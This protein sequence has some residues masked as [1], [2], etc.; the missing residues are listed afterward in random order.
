MDQRISLVTL[1]V[2]DLGAA[3]AF[4]E[5]G[6]GW[7]PSSASTDAAAFYQTGSMA[8]ALCSRDELARDVG[9]PLDGSGATLAVNL[10]SEPEVDAAFAE[11]RA[12]GAEAVKPPKRAF[13][14]GYSGYV[15]IPGAA[16]LLEI[17]FNPVFPLDENGAPRLP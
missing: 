10:R 15:R 3:R 9:E 7:R 13:W 8:L 4:F 11:A 12:A 17:A 2:E 16:H 6:L 5:E 14:G 1:V